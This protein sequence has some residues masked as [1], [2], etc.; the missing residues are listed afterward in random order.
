[1]SG[2]R[3]SGPYRSRAAG[4]LAGTLRVPGDK[5]ISHRSIIFGTLAV[6]ET[7]VEGLLEAEDV[8]C[9]VAAM[10]A[11]G[12]N[13]NKDGNGLWRIWGV[14]TGGLTSP[15]GVI[16][17]GNSGTAARLI[18]G[19]LTPQSLTAT[20]TGDASLSRRP[21]QRVLTPLGQMGAQFN[22]RAGDRLP[23]TI[24]GA[25]DPMP[26]EYEMPVASA[27]VKSA[28]LLAALNTPGTTRVLE[29]QATRDHTERMLRHFGVEVTCEQATFGQAIS[30]TGQVDLKPSHVIVPGD[31][32]S[33]AFP[34]AAALLLPGSHI[35][36]ENV[37]INPL[38]D[39][40]L[41]AIDAMGADLTIRNKR[42]QNGETVADLEV[43]SGSLNSIEVPPEWA[44][45]M[46]D[47][48]PVL[49]VLAAAA[50]GKTVMRGLQ[51]LRVK[52][53]DRLAAMAQGLSACGINVQELEDGLIIEGEPDLSLRAGGARVET[54]LDHR[55][56]MSFLVLGLATK[57]PV[58]IDDIAMIATSFPDFVPLMETLGAQFEPAGETP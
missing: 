40:F 32:S 47:E 38:R 4:P 33:A 41:R 37:G 7:T 5:S 54:F 43:K 56:A 8:L 25:A 1:M 13:I 2:R 16:D 53:S 57:E 51:E 52:E 30:L 26:I 6:G 58:A 14:G 35:T 31:V 45:S 36:I 49:A 42:E 3:L 24:E 19:A 23:I 55:I 48:Y 29:K 46:I 9:T 28:I 10:R 17:L 27:Q 50:S 12:A 22:C 11:C 39:G 44:P 15:H 34:I 20:L 21:M 18:L